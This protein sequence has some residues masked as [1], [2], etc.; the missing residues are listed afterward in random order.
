MR[1]EL[2]ISDVDRGDGQSAIGDG[3]PG[4]V[5]TVSNP[6]LGMIALFC[7]VGLWLTFYYLHL[8]QSFASFGTIL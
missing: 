5:A 8:V 2:Q 3:R 6:E 7:A 4:I 1:D